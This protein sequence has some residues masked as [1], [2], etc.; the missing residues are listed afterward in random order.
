MLVN[1]QGEQSST[2]KIVLEDGSYQEMKTRRD[3]LIQWG[4]FTPDQLIVDITAYTS[5][6]HKPSKGKLIELRTLDNKEYMRASSE[7]DLVINKGHSIE[8]NKDRDWL[9]AQGWYERSELG[10]HITQFHIDG[11]FSG[12]LVANRKNIKSAYSNIPLKLM[13]KFARE[14][15]IEINPK[16]EDNANIILN[17]E[18]D[19]LKLESDITAYINA[20]GNSSK[21]ED[22]IENAS[23]I[24]IRHDHLHMSAKI[25]TGYKPRIKKG[26]R[27]RYYFDG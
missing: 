22:W 9:V 13:A 5:R 25:K 7:V 15:E 8:L 4:T 18:P 23:L 10:I 14:N 1:K 11:S 3:Q 27:R 17:K 20:R 2:V 21:P 19:L 24:K 12:K 6:G 16:L 26:N